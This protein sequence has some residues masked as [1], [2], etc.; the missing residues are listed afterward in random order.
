MENLSTKKKDSKGDAIPTDEVKGS[1]TSTTI[2][3]NEKNFRRHKGCEATRK[4]IAF[5]H[6]NV[7]RVMLQEVCGRSKGK[8]AKCCNG[9]MCRELFLN[10]SLPE[11][12]QDLGLISTV[13]LLRGEMFPPNDGVQ[14]KENCASQ[15]Q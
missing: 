10:R 4:E 13:Q 6:E 1:K 7:K 8:N 3:S 9:N 2:A 11:E 14:V 12:L 15:T 5:N